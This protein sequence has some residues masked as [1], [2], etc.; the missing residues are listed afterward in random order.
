M[1]QFNSWNIPPQYIFVFRVI[2]GIKTD[3]FPQQ[4][5]Q[6]CLYNGNSMF[7]ARYELN[8]QILF[9]WIPGFIA[10]CL[11][12]LYGLNHQYR[13]RRVSFRCTRW[14]H[15]LDRVRKWIGSREIWRYIPHWKITSQKLSVE[16]TNMLITGFRF[17]ISFPSFL[18]FLIYLSSSPFW[19]L[20]SISCYIFNKY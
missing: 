18:S 7:P 6:I 20:G 8:F 17:F 16:F 2:L 4:H 15:L 13:L 19:K 9:R 12:E 5:Q 10:F 1:Y 11:H 3:Y 14:Q